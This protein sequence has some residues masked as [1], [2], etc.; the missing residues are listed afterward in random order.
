MLLARVA[1]TICSTASRS[2]VAPF[3]R[4]L[5]APAA[6]AESQDAFLEPVEGRPG[7]SYLSLNRPKARNAISVRMIEQIKE[8]LNTAQN[9]KS[10]GAFCAGADLV[11]RKSMSKEEVDAFLANLRNAFCSLEDLPI[12]TIAAI[13]GPALGGGLEMALCCDL[14]VAGSTVTKIGLPETRLGIIPGAGGTQR[15]VRLLGLPRAKALVYTGRA[16]DAKEA[17]SWGIVDYVSSDSQSASER[18]LELADEMSGSG[19]KA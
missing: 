10:P 18:A 14:R 16:L 2:T 6:N 17:L 3:K 1:T 4:L 8:A 13:D 11:E 15:A 19:T 7:V 5:N 9:D 12:P